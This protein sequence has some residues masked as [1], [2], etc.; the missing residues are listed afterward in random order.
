MTTTVSTGNLVR[1]T[2]IAPVAPKADVS[3]LVRETLLALPAPQ[4]RVGMIV[5]ETLM[6]GFATVRTCIFM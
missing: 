5:R 4:A 1:E 2:L 3:N 6:P